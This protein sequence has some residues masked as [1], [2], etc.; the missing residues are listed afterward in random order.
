MPVEQCRLQCEKEIS[1]ELFIENRKLIGPL[2]VIGNE[3]QYW[4]FG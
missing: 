3:K 2:E 1:R 4:L